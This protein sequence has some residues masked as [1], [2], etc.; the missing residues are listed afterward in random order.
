V[1]DV[2]GRPVSHVVQQCHRALADVVRAGDIAID[3]TLGNGHDAF[4]LGKCVGPEGHVYAFEIQRPAIDRATKRIQ[5]AGLADRIT[6][7]ECGHERL[8]AMVPDAAHRRVGAVVFNLGFLPGSDK[9]VITQPESTLEALH[10]AVGVLRPGGI[11]AVVAYAGHH[12]GEEEAS[13]VRSFAKGLSRDAFSVVSSPSFTED[14][15]ER[16]VEIRKRGS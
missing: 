8:Q 6:V 16:F 1:N 5:E 13:A 15:R 10:Q 4:F 7:L 9:R 3:A 14:A 12:G 2:S 11:V